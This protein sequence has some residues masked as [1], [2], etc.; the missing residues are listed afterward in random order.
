[1]A[2]LWS[3]FVTRQN[4][5]GASPVRLPAGSGWWFVPPSGGQTFSIPAAS[6][7]LLGLA[8]T[9]RQAIVTKYQVPSAPV[10]IT[11][12]TPKLRVRWGV[13]I[14]TS[15]LTTYAP[16]LRWKIGYQVPAQSATLTALAP[17]FR[18]I[19]RFEVPVATLTASPFFPTLKTRHAIPTRQM[20]LVGSS[21]AYRSVMRFA[22]PTRALGLTGA[23]PSLR[24][25]V[26]TRYAIPVRGMTI[27]TGVGA[28]RLR[29]GVPSKTCSMA[30]QVPVFRQIQKW[31][32]PAAAAFLL[33]ASAPTFRQIYRP[34]SASVQVVAQA[35]AWHSVRR[36]QVPATNVTLTPHAPALRTTFRVPANAVALVPRIPAWRS[37]IR[38]QVPL[39]G[40][41]LSSAQASFSTFDPGL[42]E[43]RKISRVLSTR[44]T[45]IDLNGSR[46]VTRYDLS[47]RSLAVEDTKNPLLWEISERTLQ[48][49]ITMALVKFPKDPGERLTLELNFS[50]RLL[51][52]TI[53][54]AY[55]SISQ[56]MGPEQTQPTMD[57]MLDGST[58]S[59]P[60]SSWVRQRIKDGELG[61]S[62]L[63]KLKATLS[64]GDILVGSTQIDVQLGA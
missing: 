53:T 47:E 58:I 24:M 33:T 31:A 20:T 4:L 45:L 48:G 12:Q 44:S 54:A 25:L 42:P 2:F 36:L 5:S 60:A 29:Y 51:N 55:A 30:G 61:C 26:T 27:T 41:A 43:S 52:R 15:A 38:Y 19:K 13:P 32:L 35:P 57:A 7:A 18:S 22:V 46:N 56:L 28:L 6:V 62:Y 63:V 39:A 11:G 14:A 17:A 8:P 16:V 49:D 1:M 64:D 59:S 50:K 21:P 3:R 10:T 34:A 37:T 23:T 9:F 40:V